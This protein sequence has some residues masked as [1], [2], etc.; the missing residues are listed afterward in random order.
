MVYA[1]D[2]QVS[3]LFFKKLIRS[4]HTLLVETAIVSIKGWAVKQESQ[5]LLVTSI[6]KAFLRSP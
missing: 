6:L 1:E 4:D 3:S 5:R 2:S